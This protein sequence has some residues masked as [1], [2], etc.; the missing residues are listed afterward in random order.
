LRPGIGRE[1]PQSRK[2]AADERPA[3]VL[4]RMNANEREY[5]NDLAQRVIG[6]AYDVSNTLGTGFLD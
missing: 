4:P 6:A 1:S 5:L 3:K 2:L